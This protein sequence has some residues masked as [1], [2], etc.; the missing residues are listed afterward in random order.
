[1]TTT[2]DIT[3]RFRINAGAMARTGHDLA[4]SLMQFQAALLREPCPPRKPYPR[5]YSRMTAREYR[6]DRRRWNREC[7]AYRKATR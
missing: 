2:K 4:H 1:M 3:F 7:R 5:R 6:A